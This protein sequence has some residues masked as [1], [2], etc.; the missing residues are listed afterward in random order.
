MKTTNG[1]Q[2]CVSAPPTASPSHATDPASGPPTSA[3]ETACDRQIR[4][5]NRMRSA[6]HHANAAA[7]RSH[8]LAPWLS[9]WGRHSDLMSLA[10]TKML[11]EH[12]AE[13]I[14]SLNRCQ[15]VLTDLRTDL[16]WKE[17]D[18]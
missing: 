10:D 15:A 18:Q 2:P 1:D 11:F 3:A 16:F 13:A 4:R 5:T 17:S 8:N 9:R 12:L 6:S 14:A 7:C